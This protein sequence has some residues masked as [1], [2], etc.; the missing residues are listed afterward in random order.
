VSHAAK[1]LAVSRTSLISRMTTLGI[2]LEK[3]RRV[4]L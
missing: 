3:F 2:D 4:R 1:E